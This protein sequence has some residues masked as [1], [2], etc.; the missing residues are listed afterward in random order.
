MW[1][2]VPAV[3][4][5]LHVVPRTPVCTPLPHVTSPVPQYVTSPVPRAPPYVTSPYLPMSRPPP[6]GSTA[7]LSVDGVSRP[8]PQQ[9]VTSLA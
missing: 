5:Q 3:H 8:P 4:H 1:R 9:R 2:L 7:R 6:L